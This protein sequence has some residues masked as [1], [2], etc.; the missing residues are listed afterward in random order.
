MCRCSGVFISGGEKFECRFY[1]CC[2]F[3]IWSLKRFVN[4]VVVIVNGDSCVQRHVKVYGAVGIAS[5]LDV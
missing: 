4:A 3:V 5:D 1:I 2:A